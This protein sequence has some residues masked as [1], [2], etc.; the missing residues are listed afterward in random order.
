MTCSAEQL[1]FFDCSCDRLWNSLHFVNASLSSCC[2]G[3]TYLCAE[4]S[5]PLCW[6]ST[7][8]TL[9][10]LFTQHKEYWIGDLPPMKHNKQNSAGSSDSFSLSSQNKLNIVDCSNVSNK[11]ITKFLLCRTVALH[12]RAPEPGDVSH[13]TSLYRLRRVTNPQPLAVLFPPFAHYCI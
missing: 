8:Q 9:V 7:C 11:S 10:D 13:T 4:I 5:L 1:P 6:C 12:S 3:E 2:L